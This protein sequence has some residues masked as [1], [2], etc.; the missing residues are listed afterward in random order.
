MKKKSRISMAMLLACLFMFVL[1]ACSG[2][3]QPQDE[4]EEN[5][6]KAIANDESSEYD[7]LDGTYYVR[8]FDLCCL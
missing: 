1:P 3:A 4:N 8:L 6:S 5:T 2:R 7:I